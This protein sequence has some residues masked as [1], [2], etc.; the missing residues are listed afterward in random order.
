LLT[1]GGCGVWALVDFI[2]IVCGKYRNGN[3]Q[4][5]RNR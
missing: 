2:L 1:F 3:G 5:V 4:Y